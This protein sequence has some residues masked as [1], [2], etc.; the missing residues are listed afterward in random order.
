MKLP[1]TI[2]VNS[3]GARFLYFLQRLLAKVSFGHCRMHVYLFC[4][5]PIRSG[6]FNSLRDDAATMVHSVRSGSPLVAHFPRPP[7]VNSRRFARGTECYAITVKGEFAGHIWFAEH[8][9][10]EDEV[11]CRYELPK[12]QLSIWDYD[13]YVEPR[14]RLGRTLSRLWKGVDA[15]MGARGVR[16]SISRISLS[17]VAS[18]QTH[19]RMGAVHLATGAFLVIG[20]LQL[21]FF[22]KAPY[23]H[24]SLNASQCPVI[25]LKPPAGVAAPADTVQA[26]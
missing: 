25:S 6:V 7:E 1:M 9:Y 17:N 8:H 21:S 19:E 15:V 12:D 4:A 5:Q 24:I 13:V 16:W 23:L 18:I 26:R 14:Y 11:R 2:W 20:W 3:V 10:D 22:S